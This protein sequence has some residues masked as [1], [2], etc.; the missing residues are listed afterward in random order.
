MIHALTFF[1]KFHTRLKFRRKR[2]SSR[3]PYWRECS[4]SAMW[5]SVFKN[6]IVKWN[7]FW[8]SV[9]Y[10]V[11]WYLSILNW[12]K[13]VSKWAIKRLSF[14][15]I[16]SVRPT[17]RASVGSYKFSPSF[18]CIHFYRILSNTLKVFGRH[19]LFKYVWLLVDI[20]H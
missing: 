10:S 6:L 16:M 4:K 3:E 14:S 15:K 2:L 1:Q 9:Y 7:F 5:S 8:D 18:F 20:R 19:S 12:R 13:Q 11:I 17:I